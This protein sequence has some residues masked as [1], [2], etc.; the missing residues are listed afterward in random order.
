MFCQVCATPSSQAFDGHNLLH[1]ISL[2]EP[3]SDG[4][5]QMSPATEVGV[6]NDAASGGEADLSGLSSPDE[7]NEGGG[8]AEKVDKAV[9]ELP[10]DYEHSSI[11]MSDV[12]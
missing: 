7:E 8:G 1:Q 3:E 4:S 10:Q 6:V 5:T 12:D 11:V 2:D 9:E